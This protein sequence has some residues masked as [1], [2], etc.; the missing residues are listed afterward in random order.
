MS[1][2]ENFGS[3]AAVIMAL[4]GSAIG[5]GNIWRFPYIVGEYGGAAFILVYIICSFVLSLPILFSES[6]IGRKT[7]LST[8]GAMNALAPHSKWKWLGLLTVVTPM[9]IVSYYSVVGGWAID[10]LVKSA[11]F[12]FTA[13]KAETVTGMFGELASSVWEPIVGLF[14]FLFMTA[15]IVVLGIK[16]GIEKFSNIS[17]PILFV[18]IVAIVIYSVTLPG[19]GE[20][21]RYLVKPDFS[22]LTP[23]AFSA[24]LGQSFFSLSLGVGTMLTYSS[25]VSEKENLMVSGAGTAVFDLLF[26]ILAGFA[27]MPAVF[28]AGIA[29]SSGP[30]LIFETLPYI[31]AKMSTGGQIVSYVVAIL[32]FLTVLVAALSSSVS[33]YEVG[34]AYLV[35]EKNISRPKA[36]ILVFFATFAIGILCSLSF[37]P[38]SDVKILGNSIFNFCDKLCSNYLMALGALLFSVFVG[39]K[40][41]RKSVRD[42]LTNYGTLKVNSK[43]F[44]VVYF[45]IRYI[46]PITVA[47]IFITSLVG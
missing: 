5:L 25:Y 16:K 29:P 35:E 19:A 24:A 3:R 13:D 44:P 26:A 20:G 46:A 43:L 30:G 31:F 36:T 28:A 37:G 34:V 22:K 9:I 40:M 39:W 2:R 6:V 38:L 32:F 23:D 45:L 14:A 18:L 8:F 15:M 11:T 1:N 17:I 33:I 12:S 42:E 7:H 10:Y 27:I 4:A 21:V 41:D 47:V